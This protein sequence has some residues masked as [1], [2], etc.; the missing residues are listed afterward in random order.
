MSL[1]DYLKAFRRAVEKISDYGLAESIDVREEIRASKQAVINAKI[2]LADES[3]VTIH[4]PYSKDCF[5]T[6]P[7][8]EEA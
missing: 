8:W 6:L 7:A 4:T 2:V 5:F 1:P 3:V